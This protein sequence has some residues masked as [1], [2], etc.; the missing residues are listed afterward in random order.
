MIL[1]KLPAALLIIFKG[2]FSYLEGISFFESVRKKMS[3]AAVDLQSGKEKVIDIAKKY[4]YG[5]LTAFSRAFQSVHDFSPARVKKR[6]ALVK[7]LPP[8]PFEMC[9]KGTVGIQNTALKQRKRFTFLASARH[10]KKSWEKI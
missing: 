3:L 8:V 5:A 10:R 9:R 1:R 4:G 7:T 2:C 6:N